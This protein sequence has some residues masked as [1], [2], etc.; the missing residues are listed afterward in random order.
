VIIDVH[1][2][3]S[4]PTELYAYKSLLL[5]GRGMHGAGGP[6]LSDDKIRAAAAA[7]ADML[8]QVGT[9][10]Q[11][12]SPR[13][14]HLMHSE[15]PERMVRWWVAANNDVIAKVCSMF[16]TTFL[17]VCGLPQSARGGLGAC[18][19]ELERG[20]R[21]L[22]FVG[23]LLNPDPSEGTE[24]TPPLGD[25][26]WFPLYE[27]MTELGV[28]ALMH[29]AG[30]RNP[31]LTYSLNFINEES[32]AVMSLLD[33][34]SR[35]FETFPDL[36]IIV[37]HGGGSVPY[38]LGRWQSAARIAGASPFEERLRSLWFDTTLYSKPALELLISTVGTDR[39]MFGTELP[40]SGGG[41]DPATGR[42]MDDLRPVIESI[43]WLTD[44]DRELIFADNA[45]ALHGKDAFAAVGWTGA[46]S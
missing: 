38:Q 23:C 13:P 3:L 33:E 36:K 44:R 15:T 45:V 34:D 2:H 41:I 21:E 35:V 8:A 32:I 24:V 28:P 18:L 30:C 25:E 31:R 10:V 9:D 37:P 11:L 26:Y 12:L 42:P 7:H 16:P 17:G 29:P 39:V 22:G 14:F 5:A 4:A 46:A 40:G 19:E 27:R 1:G 20:V 43:D 6:G